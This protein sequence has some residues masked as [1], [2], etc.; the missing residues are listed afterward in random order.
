MTT[1]AVSLL[2]LALTAASGAAEV[3]LQEDF[4][5]L[6]DYQARWEAP[7]GWSLVE[8][9]IDGKKTTV[10]DAQGGGAGLSVQGGLEDFDFRADFRVVRGSEGTANVLR[11]RPASPRPTSRTGRPI[12]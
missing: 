3:V 4:Q 2:A 7:A 11:R 9:E 10:L 8:A 12:T 5:S 6:E 1:G